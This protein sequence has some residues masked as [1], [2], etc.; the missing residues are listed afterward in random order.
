M[1]QVKL[2][3]DLEKKEDVFYYNRA[4]KS[5]DMSNALYE[6]AMLGDKIKFHLEKTN[7]NDDVNEGA[8][9]V[10]EE[11]NKI[12]QKFDINF[13]SLFAFE[14]KQKELLVEEKV[15]EQPLIKLDKKSTNSGKKK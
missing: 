7:A 3:Y 5:S 11:V 4:N 9:L 8:I 14:D 1:P 12:I 15:E 10:I 2:V 6:I 13:G